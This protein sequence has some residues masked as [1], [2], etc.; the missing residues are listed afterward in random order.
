MIS[1]EMLDKV[2]GWLKDNNPNYYVLLMTS[3]EIEEI[4]VEVSSWKSLSYLNYA[5]LLKMIDEDK[6]EKLEM[7]RQQIIMGD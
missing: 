5:T 6:Y 1:S 3:T 2:A 7:Y 4:V